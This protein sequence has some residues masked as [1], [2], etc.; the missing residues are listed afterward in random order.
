MSSLIVLAVILGCVAYQ[1]VK[2]TMAKG[3]ATIIVALC[4]TIVAFAFFELLSGFFLDKGSDSRFPVLVPYAQPLCFALIFILAFGLLQTAAMQL[5]REPIDFGEL[6]ER[7]GRVVCG[8]FLG[9]ILSGLLLVALG[10]APLP[11]SYP[12]ERFD[13]RNPNPEKPSKVMPNVDGLMTG[14]FSMVSKGSFRA[15]SKPKSFAVL[16]P[17]F[18]DQLYLNRYGASETVSPVA[19]KDS[20][21]VLPKAGFWYAPDDLKD[22]EGDPVSPKSGHRLMIVRVGWKKSTLTD[23]GNFT[24]S[25]IRLICKQKGLSEPAAVGQGGNVYSIGYLSGASTIE[26]KRLIEAIKIDREDF[27]QGESKKWIDFV[28]NVPSDSEPA[29]IEFKLNNVVE[30]SS[31]ASADEIPAP[32]PFRQRKQGQT[33]GNDQSGKRDASGGGARDNRNASGERPGSGLSPVG[34]TLTG[35]ALEEDLSLQ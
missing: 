9:V 8:V 33:G 6:P 30:L 18:L 5:M 20:L 13:D 2:G 17:N 11:K 19:R 22:A 3:V 31:L 29:L 27:K 25:Q 32:A 21:E 14:W 15:I 24:L 34:T 1:Y 28:F 4:A 10:M 12:Y 23:A 26:K 7:I 16:H 35:G